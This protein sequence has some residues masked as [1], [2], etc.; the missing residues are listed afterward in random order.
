MLYVTHPLAR[1]KASLITIWYGSLLSLFL[2][3]Y[4][5]NVPP[6]RN[7][8]ITQPVLEGIEFGQMVD[9]GIMRFGIASEAP[10]N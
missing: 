3:K 1:S 8:A 10:R 4:C 7:S 9:E 6:V 2:N 5:F